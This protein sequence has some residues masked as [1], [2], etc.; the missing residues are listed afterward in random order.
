MQERLL[1]EGDWESAWMRIITRHNGRYNAPNYAIDT[2][3]PSF[4]RVEH[5]K[6]TELRADDTPG[7]GLT[8]SVTLPIADGPAA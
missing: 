5:R 7:G 2:V 1:I 8:M 6:D 4:G 3:P